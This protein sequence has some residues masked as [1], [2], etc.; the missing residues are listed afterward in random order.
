M[1]E[2]S[3]RQSVVI[4]DGSVLSFDYVP[5][6]LVCREEQEAQ[7]MMIFRTVVESGR[8]E[9][10]FFSGSVGTGKTAMAKRFVSD[11]MAYG[12]KNNV[13][14]DSI[15][16]NCRFR[17]TE[18]GVLLECLRHYDAGFPDRGFSPS[19]MLRSLKGWIAKSKKRLIIVLDEV[20]NLLKKGPTD[21]IYQLSRFNEE[22]IDMPASVSLILISQE[23]VID[24]LDQA[25]LSTFRKANAIRFEPYNEEQM[26][27]ILKSRAEL[28]LRPGSYDD[29]ILRMIAKA[30]TQQSGHGDKLGD[31]RFAIDMLDK[32]ARL[33]ET[34][35]GGT[36]SGD[37]VRSVNDMVF[38]VVNEPKLAALDT[39]ELLALLS[40]AR[41]IRDRPAVAMTAS[42]KTY[43]VVCEEYE[44]PAKKHTQY[45]TYIK[46]LK[47]QGI[48]D[49]EVRTDPET[50]GRTTFISLLDIPSKVL[51]RKIQ[52]ILDRDEQ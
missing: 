34:K 11:I 42:E 52:A 7:L 38:S 26:L 20:D 1:F 44:T 17:G 19:E 33:A 41:S 48:I 31:A 9:T 24:R 43:A 50:G 6:K 40:V 27:Q 51:D 4:K 3:D 30:A 14:M 28:A 39:N 21:I 46:S 29:E 8:S 2:E 13:P 12:S 35:A 15:I 45:W 5:K 16:I 37:D 10:A 36:I 23:Y 22:S 25:S 32:A 47:D 18:A 49:T